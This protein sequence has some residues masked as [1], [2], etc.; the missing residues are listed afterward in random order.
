MA[1]VVLD[2]SVLIALLNVHDR[3]HQSA[4]DAT[5]S[6][7]EFLISAI[8]LS[9]CL[10]ARFRD[11]KEAAESTLVGIRKVAD[12]IDV[13]L[14]IAM[15]A[16]E[17]RASSALKTPDAIISATATREKAALWTFDKKLALAHPKSKLLR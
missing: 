14:E 5:Q 8:S 11:S 7:N 9:E 10:V 1:R 17:K 6:R 16:S 2:S 4:V 3:H 15:I 12:V 13:D